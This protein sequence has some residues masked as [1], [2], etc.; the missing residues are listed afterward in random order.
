VDA[1]ANH[2]IVTLAVALCGGQ[3]HPVDTE[4]VAVKAHEIAPGRFAW[5]KHPNQISLD[6]VRK[7]LW[8]AQST[9]KGYGYVAGSERTGWTLTPAGQKFATEHLES[10]QLSGKKRQRLSVDEKR[11]VTRERSRLLESPAVRKFLSG[12]ISEFTQRE[13]EFALRLDYVWGEMR[14]RKIYRVLDLLGNDQVLGPAIIAIA[15][16]LTPGIGKPL[17]FTPHQAD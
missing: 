9:E 7:R 2:E 13:A 10:T 16:K 4:D 8:D 11:W 12:S 15:K 14:T 17:A 3:L 5:R 6:A 1:L